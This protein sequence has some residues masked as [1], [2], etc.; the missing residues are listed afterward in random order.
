MCLSA[1]R[2]PVIQCVRSIF[3]ILNNNLI[4]DY[5]PL[6]AC[7]RFESLNEQ[8]EHH[9][10]HNHHHRFM[11]IILGGPQ[12]TERKINNIIIIM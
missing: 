3:N 5:L 7:V 6:I 4:T 9:N 12:I 8:R 10:H 2:H 11:T 1:V